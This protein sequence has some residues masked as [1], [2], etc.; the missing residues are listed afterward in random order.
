MQRTLQRL[1]ATAIKN[2]RKP[3]YLND[4]GG[5]YLQIATGG[6]KSWIFRYQLNGRPH[7]MGL[8]A[9][10]TFSLQE[11]R[12]R[13]RRCRQLLADGIDPI[14]EK[15]A[16]AQ[17]T[18]AALTFDQCAARYVEAHRSGWRNAKHADQWTATLKTYASPVFGARPVAQVDTELVRRAIADIWK[19]KTETASRVRSR[20][21]SVL[22]W[23]TVHGYRT[24]D[25]PARWRGH[26][27][28]LLPARAKVRPVEHMEALPYAA[29][30]EF[31]A[32]LRQRDTLGARAL[33][34]SILTAGRPGQVAGA[35]WDEIDL[36]AALWT[37]PAARMKTRR[38][39]EVP[40]SARAVEILQ[41]L[42]EHK[43]SDYVFPGD[44]TPRQPMTTAAMLKHAKQATG[45][46]ITAHGFRSSFK[47][48]AT[49]QTDFAGEVSEM[50]L[51]HVVANKVEAAYRRGTLR[52][53]R[54]LLMDA[55]ATY[56]A[57]AA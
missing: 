22:A 20:I 27:D 41:A 34:L 2:A 6:S 39:H 54:R 42:A 50:A 12:E 9:V 18:A 8:G 32:K 10:S 57:S 47:D 23:A 38:S 19:T 56:C 1:S 17:S 49:E 37:I 28:Q 21:E 40:L 45:S 26:L 11:A 52:D 46:T 29:V 15:R 33:E 30:P 51:A 5:L 7:M 31:M 55:W 14:A 13:A 44:R 48:W 24:G 16:R 53:K 43:T 3:G 35:R 4:G 36:D 25:N